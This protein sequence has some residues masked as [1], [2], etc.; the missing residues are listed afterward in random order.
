MITVA[1]EA[2][3]I[4]DEWTRA[5]MAVLAD[6]PDGRLCYLCHSETRTM[7][8]LFYGVLLCSDCDD[9]EMQKIDGRVPDRPG[10]I[11]ILRRDDHRSG[12]HG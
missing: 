1:D 11:Q 2:R 8:H 9:E 6:K 3:R 10:L 5:T 7:R 12:H 4:A